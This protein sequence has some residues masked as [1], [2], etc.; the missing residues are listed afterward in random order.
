MTSPQAFARRVGPAALCALLV[1]GLLVWN[2]QVHDLAAHVFRAE[3]FD[4]IGF[5][6]WNGSWYGGHYTLTYSVLFPPLAALTSFQAVGAASVVVATLFFDLIVRRCWG[7]GAVWGSLWFAVNA[8]LLYANAN[9][10]FA[11][12]AAFGLAALF[13]LSRERGLPAALLAL[14]CTLA[15]PLAGAFLGG[16]VLVV[17]WVS[18]PSR[19]AAL[20]VAAAALLP[21]LA[22]N[23]VFHEP[24]DQPYDFA[25]Y[26]PV[27]LWCLGALA[28]TWR[29][30]GERGVRVALVGYTLATT[31]FVL[32][33]SPMGD[34]VARLGQFFGGPVL[35]CVLLA[36]RDE[37]LAAGQ[38]WRLAGLGAIAIAALGWSAFLQGQLD[39]VI[40]GLQLSD[41][42]S[43]ERAYFEP[44]NEWLRA[45]GGDVA[46]IE[47]PETQ[48]RWENAYVAPAFTLARGWM[49]QMD[50]A[51]NALFFEGELTPERYHEWL[52][53]NG[54]RYVA[55][56]DDEPWTYSEAEADVIRGVPDY[57]ALRWDSEHWRVWEVTDAEPLVS[58]DDGGE[59]ELVAMDQES[60]SLEVRQPGTFRV[61]VHSSAFWH[62][63]E[64]KGCVS[65]D[66]EWTQVRADAP[67]TLRIEN[68]FSFDRAWDSLTRAEQEC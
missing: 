68:S 2:P 21:A 62:V 55:L 53:E 35:L 30:P 28:L 51:R 60:V 58:S 40:L 6:I 34:N 25:A 17:A 23:A 36:H 66:A 33:E 49:R 13:A 47:I 54:V 14:C 3:L 7:E 9:L 11:L 46:R 63:V 31:L 19:G 24:G 32:V 15:S 50:R 45:N 42:P 4:R 39:N 8:A 12:G 10:A 48:G 56:S 65:G 16:A 38:R 61:L 29:L 5:G 37:L 59:A 67:G 57:L 44:L 18:R 64:G 22:L 1:A 20:A 52:L 26:L 41:E 27:P 43:A